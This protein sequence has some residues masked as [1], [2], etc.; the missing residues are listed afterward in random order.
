MI[1]KI[2]NTK[3]AIIGGGRFCDKLLRHLFGD[4]FRGR[5][6]EVLGVAD[7]NENA[8]GIAYARSLGIYTCSDYR[9]ICLLEGLETIIE[10]TWDLDL[11]RTISRIKPA[12]VELIDHQDSRF[13]WDLLQLETIRQDALDALATDTITVE[14]VKAR[15]HQCFLKTADIVMQRNRRFKQIETELYEKEKSL[16]Q[17]IQGSTIPTF[18]IDRNHV[19][20][21]WNRA[22]EILTGFSADTMVGTRNHWKPFRKR[23]RPIMADVI[24]D[25]LETGEIDHYYGSKWQPSTLVEGGFEAQEFFEHLG[26]GGRWLFFTA[27]PIKASDGTII[28]AIETLWDTTD[29][30]RAEVER[31]NYTRRIE[32]SERTLSQIIQGSTIPT[33][34]LNRDHVITHWNR[35]LEKLTGFPAARMVGTRHQW[36]PFWESERPCMADVIMEPHSEAELGGLYGEHWRKST[37]IEDAYEAEVFFPKLGKG[38]RWCWFTATPL[39]TAD[40]TVVGAIETFWDTTENKRTE[41]ESRRHVKELEEKEQTLSQ[42]IQGSTT[43]TFVINRHHIVTHWNQALEKLTGFAASEIVGTSQHWKPFR[44]KARPIMADVIL[45]QLE[46]GEIS[47]YYGAKWRPSALVEGAYEAEE[48]FDHL[49]ENGRWLIFTAAPIKASDGTVVGAIE[50]LW[51]ITEKKRVEAERRRDISRIEESENRLAQIIQGSTIPTFVLNRDHVITHWNHALERLSGYSITKM[52]GTRHQWVP[53]W[54]KERPTM[55]DVI[56]DQRNERE[57]W[58]L[59]GGKW[60]KSELIEGAYEAEVFFPKL[61]QGGKWLFFTAAPIRATDGSVIG[62]IETFWDTTE[63]KES[64]AQRTRYTREVEESRRKLSQIIQGSTIPTFVLNEEHVITHWNRALEKLTGYPASQMVG[65]NHQWVPFWDSDR[66]SMADV[67]L[68]QKSDQEIWDLYSGKWKKSELIDG[69][70]EAEVFFPKLGNGGKWCWFTAAPIKSADG[71]VIGAI[72]TLWDN[73]EKKQAETDRRQYTRKLEENQRTL[74]QIIQGSTIP[75]FVLNRDHTITHWN[76]ALEK[77]TGHPSSE[78]LGT[79]RQWVPFWDSERPAMADVILDQKSEQEIWDLY[80]GKW[81]KSALIDGGYEAEVFFPK[82]GK[83]GRWCWFTAAP[84]KAADGTIVGAIETLWDTTAAKRAEDE[85]RRRNRELSTLYSIYT[86]LNAPLPLQERIEGAVLEIRDFMQAESVCLYMSEDE[87]R[88]DLRYFNACYADPGY[89]QAGPE[90]QTEIMRKVSRTDKPIVF[91]AGDH[92]GQFSNDTDT[93][94]ATFAY[95]PISAKETKGL[96]VMRIERETERFSSEELHLLDL[97][98]NRI[99]ATIENALL[100]EEIVRKSNF[101]AKLIKSAND[102]IIATDEKWQTVIF[103]PAAERIFGYSAADVV[104]VKDAR[105]FLPQWVQATLT[106]TGLGK[107]ANETSPW[108]EKDIRASNGEPIPV[109]F[110]G[111]VLREKKKMMGTVAFFQDL[112]EIKRLEHELV[113]SERLAAVG[114]TVAGMAHCIKNILHGFKGGSYLMDVGLSRDNTEKMRNGWEMIQR[115]ITRTSDLVMDLLSYSK[116]REPEYESCHP[117]EIAED[118]CELLDGVARDHDVT[119]VKQFSDRMAPVVMDPRTVHRCLMN[120]VTNAIDAC[121]FDPNVDKNHQV[122]V[123][124]L[125]EEAGMVRFDV[126]DNGCGMSE[127]VRAKLF[128]SFFSTKGVKGTGLGLL[129]TAKLVE[130]HKGTIDVASTEGEGTTFSIRFPAL[131][132]DN[133]SLN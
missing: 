118:V 10:V 108:A 109:R 106:Q 62:A 55:A 131:S 54:D 87:G 63:K 88:F 46:T 122:T 69:A 49:G 20:T 73:T 52:V 97:M 72:E 31:R 67:I 58:E 107:D 132:P 68:D 9:E 36:E 123:V 17:I 110:S 78:M 65:T 15:I 23:E 33:F 115:N 1:R 124:T 125:R 121:I 82:L 18:V 39:K 112:R 83:V 61:G 6:P 101:Q 113:N 32:E 119:M 26:D 84:I 70:Y 71:S 114:Q 99:G 98:G 34:V 4:H 93:S 126:K 19:V 2:E 133:I 7:L 77:L 43:P 5:H 13:L 11:A 91:N 94:E 56:L 22:L 104:S 89:G 35:A 37:L 60:K 92:H 128:S 105:D 75:T 50:T 14:T 47:Q 117:N 8:V 66:P 74:S 80:G 127:E 85:Q 90:T 95:I 41:T 102:G 30:Q 53:F 21:H 116:E 103:N 25:Q 12:A 86:S 29:N 28:G 44:K 42:I 40:G 81:Q 129:V 96:G 76:Q 3:I 16:S 130:E 24:L 64:E 48:F 100:Q 51:D 27:A 111:T 57:I 79:N 59:Y 120:L 45:D 38:G